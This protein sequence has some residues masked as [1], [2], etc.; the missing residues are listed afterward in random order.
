[1]NGDPLWG[2]ARLRGA[3]RRALR[4][5]PH[6]EEVLV[7]LWGVW[8]E[9]LRQLGDLKGRVDATISQYKRQTEKQTTDAA[10]Q[11]EPLPPRVFPP[12]PPSP[13][14][15]ATLSMPRPLS[16]G[17]PLV[18][19][20]K[21]RPKGPPPQGA[22]QLGAPE[23]T[24][25]RKSYGGPSASGGKGSPFPK[26]P[27]RGPTGN[28]SGELLG[29]PSFGFSRDPTMGA[30]RRASVGSGSGSQNDRWRA[31]GGPPSGERA[32]PQGASPTRG[33]S[34]NASRASSRYNSR[35]PSRSLN[36][37]RGPR[38]PKAGPN[39]PGGPPSSLPPAQATKHQEETP[40]AAAAT[41]AAP[42]AKPAAAAPAAAPVS[43]ETPT[44][45][46]PGGPPLPRRPLLLPAGFARGPQQ[47]ERTSARL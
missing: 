8:F 16:M 40:G 5:A 14:I 45:L 19:Y 10:I 17:P 6:P 27:S 12:P 43:R 36:S 35:A 2:I 13:S 22:P 38:S 42:A 18:G 26:I 32:A 28:G 11:V 7:G 31:F 33:S 20:P 30:L 4:E 9:Y 37:P 44:K 24:L 25:R 21:A 41:T 39:N 3:L 47:K 34:R 15:P 1:M 29:T 23:A 46:K